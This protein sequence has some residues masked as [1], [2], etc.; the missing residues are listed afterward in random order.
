MTTFDDLFDRWRTGT[1]PVPST[2]STW[3]G[4]VRRF[5]TQ[6]GHKNPR[7][8]SKTDALRW[9]DALLAEGKQQI[10]ETY[11]GALRALYAYGVENSE[12]TGVMNNP[13]AGVKAKQKAV[14]GA[15]EPRQGSSLPMSAMIAPGVVRIRRRRPMSMRPTARPSGRLPISTASSAYCR[16]MAM[17]A[18][19]YWPRRWM[20][21]QIS[22]PID[23][24]RQGNISDN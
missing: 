5:T 21:L 9:K 23:R 14:A 15:D 22:S 1:K 2:V 10:S 24:T 4:Y 17:A 20:W 18:I 19:A 13:F 8:V 7:D 16:S 3:Q 11:L 12:T 6:L